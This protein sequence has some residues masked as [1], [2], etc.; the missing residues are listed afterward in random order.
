MLEKINCGGYCER[1]N[2][3]GGYR[4][5]LNLDGGCWGGPDEAGMS[6]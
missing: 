4:E 1:L 5:R 2:I 6:G 3:N